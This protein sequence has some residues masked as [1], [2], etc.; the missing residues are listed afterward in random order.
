M[1]VSGALLSVAL[2]A[3]ARAY[4]L[5]AQD[6]CALVSRE[7]VGTLVGASVVST[8]PVERAALHET[9]CEYV[10]ATRGT[11]VV[12]TRT[13]HRGASVAQ[14]CHA[15]QGPSIS[16]LGDAACSFSMPGGAGS[17]VLVAHGDESLH[18][19]VSRPAS[20]DAA[21]VARRIAERA[22]THL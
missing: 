3:G 5:P 4:R 19:L 14:Q 15:A 8:K 20:G 16:G 13:L 12:I 17:W 18:V 9:R 6:P 7:E 22:L 11:A 1:R 2:L 10:T 21:V